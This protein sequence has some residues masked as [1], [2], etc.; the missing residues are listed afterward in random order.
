MALSDSV[1]SWVAISLCSNYLLR[2][3]TL[4]MV[5]LLGTRWTSSKLQEA[6]QQEL[7]A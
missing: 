5:S 4:H 2:V 1:L 3:V 7:Y 6:G